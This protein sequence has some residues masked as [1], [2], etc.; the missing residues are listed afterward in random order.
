[1]GC[2][3]SQHNFKTCQLIQL[4]HTVFLEIDVR[5]SN[6]QLT[7]KQYDTDTNTW[8][9]WHLALPNHDGVIEFAA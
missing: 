7:G 6:D 5:I 3:A 4:S 2:C 8:V 1:M 9:E